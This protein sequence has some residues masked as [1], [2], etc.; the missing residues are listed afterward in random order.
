NY[1]A[2][3]VCGVVSMALGSLWFGP[4]FGKTWSVMVGMDK[5]D[6]A[7]KDAMM[8]KMWM[9]YVIMFIGALLMA[10]GLD[11]NTIFGMSYLQSSGASAG[12]SGGFW[13]WLSFV[14]PITVGA[15]LWEGKPW[16]FWMITAGYYLIQLL[17]FGWILAVWR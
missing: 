11:H 6:Q 13:T 10:Y 12:L 17:I 2:V 7:K 8:K 3:L 15:V 14:A 5:M 1:W 4:L 16:K 9:A